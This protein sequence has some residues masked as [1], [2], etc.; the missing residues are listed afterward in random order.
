MKL[1]RWDVLVQLCENA[2]V[3]LLARDQQTRVLTV[4]IEASF[5]GFCAV[6]AGRD[7]SVALVSGEYPD[8]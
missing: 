6:C 4:D 8:T 1:S 7:F 2:G 5:A 3:D